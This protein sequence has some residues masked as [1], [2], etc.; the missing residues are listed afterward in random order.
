[1]ISLSF[2]C[3]W[4]K[5]QHQLNLI[6][7][8]D[9]QFPKTVHSIRKFLLF[10]ISSLFRSISRGV[11]VDLESRGGDAFSI[12]PAHSIACIASK[13]LTS[14]IASETLILPT[15]SPILSPRSRE[16]ECSARL[17]SD[18]CYIRRAILPLREF[19]H[20]DH[21]HSTLH[22]LLFHRSRPE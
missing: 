21:D 19:C 20:N 8:K 10:M 16:P 5:R 12:P 13:T 2:V 14:K 15:R 9:T 4:H 7:M 17:N 1:M 6:S 22:E 11:L 18:A 3:G